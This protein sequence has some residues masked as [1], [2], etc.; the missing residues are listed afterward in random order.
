MAREFSRSNSSL[1]I[2][3]LENYCNGD[4]TVYPEQRDINEA[5]SLV[6]KIKTRDQKLYRPH[7]QPIFVVASLRRRNKDYKPGGKG[8]PNTR[9]QWIYYKGSGENKPC[10]LLDP[11]LGV[12]SYFRGAEW[13]VGGRKI[14]SNI[15][16]QQSQEWYTK[17][18]RTWCNYD[19]QRTVLGHTHEIGSWTKEELGHTRDSFMLLSEASYELN[20]VAAAAAGTST[21]SSGDNGGGED[22]A[23]LIP[24]SSYTLKY[25]PV[26]ERNKDFDYACDLLKSADF[27]HQK[28]PT[29]IGRSCGLDGNPFL[30]PARNL[31][32][33]SKARRNN[34]K[35][36]PSPITTEDLD[37]G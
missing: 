12:G 11:K 33:E 28:D 1:R 16:G 26:F 34:P 25:G 29:L 4:F 14:W 2:P 6:F 35:R 21:G 30:G 31:L 27:D 24:P 10:N 37:F 19:L 9:N 15:G 32:L 5:E 8:A 22:A 3:H 18:N 13:R 36:Y 7:I 23:E 20:K 17:L